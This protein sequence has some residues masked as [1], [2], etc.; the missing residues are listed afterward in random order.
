MARRGGR[1]IA[2]LREQGKNVVVVSS[3]IALGSRGLGINGRPLA[4][5]KKQAAA[6]A[7]RVTLAYWR[8]ARGTT[9]G[10]HGFCCLPRTPKPADSISVRHHVGA[11]RARRGAGRE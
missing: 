4:I 3:A 9:Y 1:D 8:E 11:S 6:A 7:G 10:S 2:D 5:E